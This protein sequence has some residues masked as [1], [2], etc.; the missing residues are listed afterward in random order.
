MSFY[1]IVPP[2]IVLIESEFI[3]KIIAVFRA[4]LRSMVQSLRIT[5]PSLFT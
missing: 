3:M 1:V 2:D 5:A 4:E